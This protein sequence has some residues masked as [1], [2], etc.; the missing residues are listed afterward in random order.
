[1]FAPT[2]YSSLFDF[3][4]RLYAKHMSEFRKTEQRQKKI[5]LRD[6]GLSVEISAPPKTRNDALMEFSEA[7]WAF[8]EYE[9]D[10]AVLSPSGAV[11]PAELWLM[12]VFDPTSPTGAYV[13]LLI[14]TVGSGGYPSEFHGRPDEEFPISDEE[15]KR[16]RLNKMTNL[17]GPFLFCPIL[18]PEKAA[19]DF[20]GDPFFENPNS[21]QDPKD[22]DLHVDEPEFST[23][24]EFVQEAFP[25]GKG[26]A[27]WSYVEEK[28]GYSRRHI[29]RAVK[30]NTDYETWARGGHIR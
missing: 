7:A 3:S 20:I 22:L 11:L 19:D 4:N 17:F 26:L 23:V 13:D 1:M 25:D 24:W 18:V 16:E 14:G 2:G 10:V 27:T 15:R 6:L 21:N 12:S 30:A 8:I 28:V 29:V 9:V 5:K